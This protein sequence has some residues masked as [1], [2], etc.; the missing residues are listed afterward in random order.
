MT[1]DRSISA[2]YLMQ[3]GTMEQAA[4]LAPEERVT[5]SN[6]YKTLFDMNSEG[7]DDV[8]VR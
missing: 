4:M 6:W 5:Y 1:P 8:L 3:A 7:I 2:D